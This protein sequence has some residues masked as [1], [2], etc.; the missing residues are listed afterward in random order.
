MFLPKSQIPQVING[1][2]AK[3]TLIR[4][5]YRLVTLVIELKIMMPVPVTASTITC[6][7]KIEAFSKARWIKPTG[8]GLIAMATENVRMFTKT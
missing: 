1:H 3:K 6:S 2:K 7:I 5:E 4:A 8:H